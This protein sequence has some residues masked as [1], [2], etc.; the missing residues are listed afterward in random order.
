GRLVRMWRRSIVCC[1]LGWGCFRSLV[2]RVGLMVVVRWCRGRPL[3]V[4]CSRVWMVL[5]GVIGRAG[6]V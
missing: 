6:L 5:L 2:V 1:L 4:G 3:V